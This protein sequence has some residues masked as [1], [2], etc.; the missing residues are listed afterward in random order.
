LKEYFKGRYSAKIL[1]GHSFERVTCVKG[2]A[3]VR[4]KLIDC[5]ECNWAIARFGENSNGL[6]F[7]TLEYYFLLQHNSYRALVRAAC[8][9][10]DEGGLRERRKKGQSG[11]D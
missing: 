7:D 2:E 9:A 8:G 10:I 3:C 6:T 5:Y 1:S 4:G 11:P